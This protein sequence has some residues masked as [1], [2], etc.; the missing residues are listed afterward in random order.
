MNRSVIHYT[1][2]IIYCILSTCITLYFEIFSNFMIVYFFHSFYN[3]FTTLVFFFSFQCLVFF[4]MRFGI[5]PFEICFL[6]KSWYFSILKI[7]VFPFQLHVFGFWFHFNFVFSPFQGCFGIFLSTLYCLL[8]W[9]FSALTDNELSA[10][11]YCVDQQICTPCVRTG[12]NTYYGQTLW[13]GNDAV[14][15]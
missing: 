7:G 13:A 4:Q 10:S 6:L 11:S 2:H 14:Y 9:R 12:N 1:L 5:F 3:F 8:N 15:G